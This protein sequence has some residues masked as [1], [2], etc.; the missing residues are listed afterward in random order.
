M[1]PS[2]NCES[3]LSG[4]LQFCLAS[5]VYHPEYIRSRLP[6]THSLMATYLFRN[7]SPIHYLRA[8]GI[9][10]HIEIYKQ[11]EDINRAVVLKY[12]IRN[13]LAESGLGGDVRV[14][15]DR[16]G[17]AITQQFLFYWDNTFH[18]LPESHNS[19]IGIA[20]LS[21]SPGVRERRVSQLRITTALR[22]VREANNHSPRSTMLHKRKRVRIAKLFTLISY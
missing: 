15:C 22:L 21:I 1:F 20:H 3:H 4:I 10:P 18:Y 7:V 9:P 16:P 19:E 2:L 13:V 12:T 5:L 14:S 6:P 8:I 17:T 11:Q